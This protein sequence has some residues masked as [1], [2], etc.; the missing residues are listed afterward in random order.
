MAECDCI[1]SGNVEKPKQHGADS[2]AKNC[3]IYSE[4]ELC[5]ILCGAPRSTHTKKPADWRTVAG[6]AGHYYEKK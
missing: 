6:C 1:A 3:A 4:P 2:H 5:C